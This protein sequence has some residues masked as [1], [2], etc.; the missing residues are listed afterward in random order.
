MR[1]REKEERW[2]RYHTLTD[3]ARKGRMKEAKEGVE[4]VE[5]KRE[6][7]GGGREAEERGKMT[8]EM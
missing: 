1:G 8:V 6:Q 3:M 7:R 2:D 4:I 5:E